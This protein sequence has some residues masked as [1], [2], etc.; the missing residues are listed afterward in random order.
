MAS[1][2]SERHPYRFQLSVHAFDERASSQAFGPTDMDEGEMFGRTVRW[3]E[4]KD[5]SPIAWGREEDVVDESV[6]HAV[7][8]ASDRREPELVISPVTSAL[9]VAS[10]NRREYVRA[11]KL[12]EDVTESFEEGSRQ[13]QRVVAFYKDVLGSFEHWFHKHEIPLPTEGGDSLS[14]KV[15]SIRAVFAAYPPSDFR[16]LKSLYERA[17]DE[18]S[19]D[20]AS[21]A[22]AYRKDFAN[23]FEERYKRPTPA[24]VAEWYEF[25]QKLEAA[26]SGKAE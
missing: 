11:R 14:N 15:D 5:D 20:Y 6:R 3:L 7:M 25:V 13:K 23:R 24:S 12:L 10:A 8:N 18:Y 17:A 4:M 16:T 19:L 9:A 2:D 26:D 21:P 22:D 1:S